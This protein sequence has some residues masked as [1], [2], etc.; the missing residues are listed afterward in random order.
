VRVLF[1]HDPGGA[2]KLADHHALRAVH[3]EGSE[4]R[5]LRELAEEDFLLDDVAGTPRPILQL[6]EDRET[7][8]RAQRRR[9]RHVSLD[10]LLDIVLGL[11]HGGRDV[12]EDEVLVGVGYG[13]DFTK[14]PVK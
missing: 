8:D 1:E 10:A 2:V 12:F 3:D 5:E 9:V 4:R 11:T 14:D 7:E 13:E 6:F